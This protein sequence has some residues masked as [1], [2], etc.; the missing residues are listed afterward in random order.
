MSIKKK[1]WNLIPES[2]LKSKFLSVYR[3]KIS[4]EKMKFIYK[5]DEVAKLNILESGLTDEG[6]AFVEL[7]NSYIFYGYPTTEIGIHFYNKLSDKI[8]KN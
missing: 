4:F 6:L 7:E 3:N 8:K 1:F 5:L 2:S